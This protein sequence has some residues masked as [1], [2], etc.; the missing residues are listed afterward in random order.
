MNPNRRQRA[1]CQALLLTALTPT[2]AVLVAA[3]AMAAVAPERAA[4]Q[5]IWT[6]DGARWVT[7]GS[8][9]QPNVSPSGVDE[10][11]YLIRLDGAPGEVRTD[12]SYRNAAGTWMAEKVM[13]RPAA[14]GQSLIAT[15]WFTNTIATP[16]LWRKVAR[17]GDK[18]AVRTG[19]ELAPLYIGKWSTPLGTLELM[20]D[21]DKVAGY[22]RGGNGAVSFMIKLSDRQLKGGERVNWEW[23][24]PTS[25]AHGE[26]V[27]AMTTDGG[28]FVAGNSDPSLPV[29]ANPIAWTASRVGAA[30]AQP[31]PA[32]S[33]PASAKPAPPANGAAAAAALKGQW[34]GDR[35]R[36][37]F[38]GR[39]LEGSV[40]DRLLLIFDAARSNAT[41][42]AGILNLG[43]YSI[44]A[45]AE[46]SSDG[47]ALLIW[48]AYGTRYMIQQLHKAADDGTAPKLETPAELIKHFRSVWNTPLGEM[49][50][51]PSTDSVTAVIND[52]ATGRPAYQLVATARGQGEGDDAIVF[53][54]TDHRSGTPKK[55]GSEVMMIM[56]PDERSIAIGYGNGTNERMGE[57][58]RFTA[59]RYGALPAES[60]GDGGT[61]ETGG[62]GA[63]GSSGGGATG[64]SGGGNS[65]SGSAG[66]G[67][68]G[69][70]GGSPLPQPA[71]MPGSDG[72]FRQ[73]RKYDVRLDRIETP[74]DDRLVHIYLTL[75]N[76]TQSQQY[77]SSGVVQVQLRDSDGATKQTGQ[78]LRPV[79][80]ALQHFGSTPVLQ[81]GEELKVQF[82]LQLDSGT[83]PTKV[84]VVEG[85]KRAEF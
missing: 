43:Q 34:V 7:I 81:P 13:L 8:A 71:P 61:S 50:F 24:D 31:V 3:P 74:R 69:P 72:G 9:N 68:S 84:I 40:N 66:G 39:S 22:I 33:S 21:Y 14:D 15:E 57:L 19:A 30:P 11:S 17:V 49:V 47:K 75:K 38:D 54:W 4:V 52:P 26:L 79:A 70:A 2:A 44:P 12:Y 18:P 77:V 45:D 5:G 82:A 16:A 37:V 80:G 76:A 55:G 63:T 32:P 48:R 46:L 51:L 83:S 1:L 6:T 85:D 78:V 58:D 73:L 10:A 27:T 59:T 42:F 53:T 67:A 36:I 28:T 64:S 62:G 29:I 35:T 56:S 20:K 65:G 25:G 60:S 41:R 23:R